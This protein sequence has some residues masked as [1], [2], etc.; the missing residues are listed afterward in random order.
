MEKVENAW[1][2]LRMGGKKVENQWERLRMGGK[3]G[4]MYGKG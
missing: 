2:K 4:R 3:G 1:E